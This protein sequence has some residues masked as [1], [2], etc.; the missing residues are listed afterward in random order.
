MILLTDGM[1]KRL[2][3]EVGLMSIRPDLSFGRPGLQQ[4]GEGCIVMIRTHQ[5]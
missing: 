4:F 3:G 5:P 2:C 1:T